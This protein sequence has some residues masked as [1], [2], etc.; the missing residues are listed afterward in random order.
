M[1]VCFDCDGC[2]VWN[3][4]IACD[5]MAKRLTAYGYPLTWQTYLLRF[6]G[7]PFHTVLEEIDSEK[8]WGRKLQDDFPL[9]DCRLEMDRRYEKE[10]IAAPGSQEA[11]K[12]LLDSGMQICVV[13]GSPLCRLEGVLRKTGLLSYFDGKIF[14]S[15]EA[16]LPSKPKP[17]IFLHAAKQ[18]GFIPQECIGI[19]DSPYGIEAIQKAGMSAWAFTGSDHMIKGY[20]ELLL[21]RKPQLSFDHMKN[22]PALARGFAAQR[23]DLRGKY[24]N[25]QCIL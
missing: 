14:S 1:L 2:L 22:L 4:A 9:E 15:Y 12:A 25:S 8:Q 24:G 6:V 3:E 16:N 18:M 5:V 19:E 11:L 21:K 23:G 10:L 7:K 17:D 20:R 13:S